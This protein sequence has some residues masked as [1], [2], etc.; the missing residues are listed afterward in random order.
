MLRFNHSNLVMLCLLASTACGQ[1]GPEARPNEYT[2]LVDTESKVI[3]L[4]QKKNYSFPQK[5]LTVDNLF[6]GARLNSAVLTGNT[7]KITI[8]PEN[9]PING[10]SWY[11]FRIVSRKRQS[12]TVEL[13][14]TY[15]SHRY[16][17]KWS[18]DGKNWFFIDKRKIKTNRDKDRVWFTIT[19]PADTLW[20]AAQEIVT[21]E[22]VTDWCTSLARPSFIRY[23]VIGQSALGKDIPCL[24]IY[25]GPAHGKP[26]IAILGRH[27]PPEVTHFE[28]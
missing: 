8:A 12:L 11:A 15:A 27:H 2:R 20:I 1:A 4:Q 13:D 24:D 6:N 23:K 9:T 18:E 26:I 7:L 19:V 3:E 25:S 14:Y 16:A 21:S 22:N 10:S 28:A 17:P 5:S